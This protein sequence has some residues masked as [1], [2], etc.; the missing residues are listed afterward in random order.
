M[1]PI[2]R[3]K[4]LLEEEIK[5]FTLKEQELKELSVE[6]SLFDEMFAYANTL[7]DLLDNK[8]RVLM[9]LK[10]LDEDIYFI[11]ENKIN[12]LERIKD[13]LNIPYSYVKIVTDILLVLT[14]TMLGGTFGV[15][16][17]I[18]ALVTGILVERLGKI[19]KGVPKK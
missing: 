13:K 19:I 10:E 15:G 5:N 18:S 4:S 3:I 7:N 8:E 17:I 9:F 12:I 2:E 1:E 14:G 6:K 16:T 11:M